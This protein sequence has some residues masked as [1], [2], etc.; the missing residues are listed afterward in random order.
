MRVIELWRYPVKAMLG[1]RVE[2]LEV[3]RGGA[4]GDR[5]W[6]VVD[7]ETQE[8]I[9]NKSG[10]T[11]PRLRACRAEVLPDADGPVPLRI[12]LPD[13][14]AVTG[15]DI[16]PAMSELLGKP[17]AIRPSQAPAEGRYAATGADHDLAPIHLITTST[18]A[19]MRAVIP[20]LDPDPRRFR[21]N[22][23]LDDGGDPDA[24]SE[25][26]LLGARL[27]GPSGVVLTVSLPCP[28]CVVPS[29]AHEEVPAFPQLLRH[30]IAEHEFDLGAFGKHGC[31]GSYA[32][33]A[34]TGAV[35]VGDELTATAGDEP[36]QAVIDA[37]VERITAA[38][39]P[40]A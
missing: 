3:G 9:A 14:R 30:L 35:R 31:A 38:R 5:G 2:A 21:P 37:A 7:L 8:R 24:W 20:G 34:A 29:R 33:V 28:R 12:T 27:G 15:A 13:G 10:P 39:A 26:A 11:D 22:L 17:V 4:A 18:I 1:E 19:R 32:E 23:L 16:D 40:A 6:I 25:D 36:H